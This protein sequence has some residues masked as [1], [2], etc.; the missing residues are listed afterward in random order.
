MT[1]ADAIC[2]AAV[3]AP[4][5]RQPQLSSWPAPVLEVRLSLCGSGTSRP[6]AWTNWLGCRANP[7]DASPPAWAAQGVP[8]SLPL[9]PNLHE[10]RPRTIHEQVANRTQKQLSPP[11]F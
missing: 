6:N 10:N 9:A 5:A 8:T 2:D 7:C 3:D 1:G 11:A 4:G